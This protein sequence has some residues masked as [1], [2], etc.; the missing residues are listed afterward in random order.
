[1]LKSKPSKFL[2]L[3]RKWDFPMF[4]PHEYQAIEKEWDF[5]MSHPVWEWD[6]QV[7]RR[8]KS[9]P[10]SAQAD[11]LLSHFPELSR[12]LTWRYGRQN[13]A[14]YSNLHPPLPPKVLENLWKTLTSFFGRQ[15]KLMAGGSQIRR[16]DLHSSD[17]DF[18]FEVP[19]V[20]V[21]TTM[22]DDLVETCDRR[23]NTTL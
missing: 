14:L 6:I 1:M 2:A 7:R 8:W 15:I 11:I 5:P 17:Y 4:H 9:M 12:V 16:T 13:Y 22:R 20:C 19:G 21:N 3:E 23:P 18:Y 10:A